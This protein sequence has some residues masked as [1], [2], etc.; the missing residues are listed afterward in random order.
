MPDEDE[1][2]IELHTLLGQKVSAYHALRYRSVD[3]YGPKQPAYPSLRVGMAAVLM[4]VAFVVTGF[5]V[6]NATLNNAEP[7]M[8]KAN[9]GV[10]SSRLLGSSVRPVPA[11][12]YKRGAIRPDLISVMTPRIGNW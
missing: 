1:D 4:C 8:V 3:S 7:K 11:S 2:I 5:A 9:G 12:Y 6:Y 10:V